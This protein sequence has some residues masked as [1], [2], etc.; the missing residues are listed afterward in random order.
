MHNPNFLS[1]NK[2]FDKNQ[3]LIPLYQ[4]EYA[5]TIEHIMQLLTDIASNASHSK[6]TLYYLGTLVLFQ[7]ET[8]LEVIDGQQRLTTLYLLMCELLKMEERDFNANSLQFE[9]RPSSKI[10]LEY[11]FG[12][13]K[14]IP[15]DTEKSILDAKD[16]I[17]QNLKTICEEFEI[18]IVDFKKYL[19]EKV[20]LLNVEVP[21]HTDLN[22]YFEIMN[23]RGEQLEK[24]ELL[25]ARMMDKLEDMNERTLFARVW[26]AS[27][28]LTRSLQLGFDSDY[29]KDIFG[30][31]WD[32]IPD[33]YSNLLMKSTS[34]INDD[35][36]KE[37]LPTKSRSE[38]KSKL[39]DIITLSEISE[40][41]DDIRKNESHLTPV[42][43]FPN[44]LLQV[45]SIMIADGSVM[46]DDKQLLLQFEKFYKNSTRKY[47]S[48][49]E[50]VREFCYFL[51]KSK[52]LFDR[53]FIKN[54]E[55]NGELQW[56]LTK[57]KYYD[58]E[59]NSSYNW[60]DTFGEEKTDLD[61][62]ISLQRDIIMLQSM[63]HVSFPTRIYKNW[64]TA[65]LCFLNR[66]YVNNELLGNN[67]RK[68]L[69]KMSDSFFFDRGIAIPIKYET[70][71]FINECES[72]I[73]KVE[74]TFEEGV[75]TKN[76]IFNRLDYKLWRNQENIDWPKNLLKLVD[77]FKFTFR[78]SVEHFMP[79]TS[80]TG[81]KAKYNLDRFGNLCL[82]DR[83][84]NSQLSNNEPIAKKS[85]YTNS[86]NI[87]SLKL[88]LM[89]RDADSWDDPVI[90]KNHESEMLDFLLE[91]S[92]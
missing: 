30:D 54:S 83:G 58:R 20:V 25:K 43:N 6:D 68:H 9:S 76:F 38:N 63:F 49:E 48:G 61:D 42:I 90:L 15:K 17:A 75:N 34:Q 26:D 13:F 77:S 79:Q 1:I 31:E 67:F 56:T 51:F 32:V 70:I 4:R 52:F 11:V 35:M 47:E 41:K 40:K 23:V 44:F 36:L 12:N 45:L 65:V 18:T 88:W 39:I 73:D 84:R 91:K 74:Y 66:G 85:F 19:L 57:L 14:D 55:D 33:N 62:N 89:M 28:N 10:S 22:H 69:W 7:R 46:L 3:Y 86:N 21:P 59:K 24:H 29:R 53:Y 50:F 37:T 80:N 27:S 78:S 82:I 8:M 87:D 2:V 72:V 5:W 16:I 92:K 81:I 64:F 60:V 71:I